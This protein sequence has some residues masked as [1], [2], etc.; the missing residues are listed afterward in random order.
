MRCQGVTCSKAQEYDSSNQRGNYFTFQSRWM[1]PFHLFSAVQVKTDAQNT[2][3]KP[4]LM[5]TSIDAAEKHFH[6]NQYQEHHQLDSIMKLLLYSS[7]PSTVFHGTTSVI[8]I[9]FLCLPL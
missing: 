2:P 7:V 8:W 9:L 4:F 6:L 1:R 5:K 3:E